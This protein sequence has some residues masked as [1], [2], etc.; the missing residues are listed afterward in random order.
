MPIARGPVTVDGVL[1]DPTWQRACFISDF[2]QKSPRYRGAPTHPMRIA[3]AVDGDTL[4]VGARMYSDPGDVD[5]ALTQRDDTRQA[6]RLVVSIDPSHTRRIA[7][8]FAVTAAG[9]RADWIHTDDTEGRR[10]YS[11]SPVWITKTQIL[12][13]GWVAEMAI[14]LSQLR[15]PREPATSWGI[16]FNW[17][18]PHRNED[19]FWRAVP[20]DRAAWASWFGELTDL[21]PIRPGVALGS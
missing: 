12:D 7:F 5:A 18:I 10:D 13:N 4:Y 11:W 16:N 2:E 9:V 8:S 15:L 19:V 1:D 17:Y 6:E 20:P 14:P 3:V 21:P